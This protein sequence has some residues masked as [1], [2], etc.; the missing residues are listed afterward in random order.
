MV[1]RKGPG[2]QSHYQEQRWYVR[3]LNEEYITSALGH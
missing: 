2:P 1:D 3:F